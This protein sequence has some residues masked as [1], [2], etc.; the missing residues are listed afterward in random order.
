MT[1][2]N[3]GDYDSI[4]SDRGLILRLDHIRKKF[5]EIRQYNKFLKIF[6]VK[7]NP[8]FRRG[9]FCREIILK[10]YQM[11]DDYLLLPRSKLEAL[12]KVGLIKNTRFIR[13]YEPARITK[14]LALSCEL[15][16]YQ[17]QCVD[18]L[19]NNHLLPNNKGIAYFS[20][21]TGAG[22]T[23]CAIGLI[24]ELKLKTLVIVPSSK[25]LQG[26][27][28]D[29]LS[30]TLPEAKAVAYHN[31][32]KDSSLEDAD[33]VVVVVNT[34]C[35]KNLDFIQSGRF[36]LVVLDEAHEL[37]SRVFSQTL[38]LIQG[39][40]YILGL[41][42]TPHARK[43]EL[44]YYVDQF[45]GPPIHAETIPGVDINKERFH[46]KITK[47]DYYGIPDYCEIILNAN[48]DT[49]N[50]LTLRR[51]VSDP[52][53]IQL[54]I[55]QIRRLYD[56]AAEHG[57]F[58]FA[59]H[60]DYL[61][62]LREQL[63]ADEMLANDTIL[64]DP[65]SLNLNYSVDVQVLRGGASKNLVQHVRKKGARIVLTTYGYSRRGIDLPN[66]SALVLVTP[67]RSGLMQVLGRIT[68]KRSDISKIRE[69]VDIVDCSTIYKNQFYERKQVYDAKMWPITR[70]VAHFDD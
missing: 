66:M 9:A 1:S 20:L 8:K 18:H 43:D 41:S 4:V 31:K 6:T 67:R 55:R 30:A 64:E 33:I 21:F 68:R 50:A 15:Y 34:F 70:E 45:L 11:V 38:W 13:S 39:I 25:D 62:L 35:K 49:N 48:G 63:L 60:R 5:P 12:T 10:A 61:V 24:S 36:G 22:K 44:D 51:V 59:E 65:D 17:T 28:I 69:V 3:M 53:R 26:Q 23:R 27:W 37:C 57:I 52:S 7:E 19:L 16:D 54:I 46:G 29:E 2:G 58:V 47:I 14:T 42:A 32:M 40:P 56:D